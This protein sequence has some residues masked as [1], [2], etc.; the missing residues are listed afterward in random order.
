[1]TAHL[2]LV[3]Q[4]SKHLEIL[5]QEI[6]ALGTIFHTLRFIARP[7]LDCPQFNARHQPIAFPSF[8][9][10]LQHKHELSFTLRATVHSNYRK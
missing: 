10:T 6:P 1:M 8:S 3:A 9:E 2:R 5:F 7:L 4:A